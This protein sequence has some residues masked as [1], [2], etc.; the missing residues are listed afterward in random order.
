VWWY[1]R[2]VWPRAYATVYT[3]TETN[4]TVGTNVHQKSTNGYV[5]T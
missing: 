1:Q 3:G 2:R 4:R 5:V